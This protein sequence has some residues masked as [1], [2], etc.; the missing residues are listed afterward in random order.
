MSRRPAAAIAAA[1]GLAAT[2]LVFSALVLVALN[3]GGEARLGSVA[4]LRLAA[5]YDRRA[6]PL[7][8]APRIPSPADAQAAAQLSQRALTVFPYDT[9]AWLRLAYLDALRHGGLSAEGVSYLTRSYDLV[10][11]DPDVAV[12]RIRFALENSQSLTPDL[13]RSVRDEAL[14]LGSTP[15]RESLRELQP[16]IQN[17]AGRLSLALWLNRLD[18]GVAK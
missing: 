10:A 7:L 5:G 6:E 18:A 1:C 14:A 2:T 8:A 16:K 15:H 3:S 12:W 4:V 13:R 17:A 9:T 11:V